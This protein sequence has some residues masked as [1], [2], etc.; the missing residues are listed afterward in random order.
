MVI[1]LKCGN[2]LKTHP[3][4][5]KKSI[6]NREENMPTT[7]C[8]LPDRKHHKLCGQYRSTHM[9][10]LCGREQRSTL[11]SFLRRCCIV[12]LVKGF[13]KAFSQFV[14][15]SSVVR[16]ELNAIYR[17]RN[18]GMQGPL[19]IKITTQNLIRS[20]QRKGSLR[21]SPSSRC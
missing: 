16:D 11:H 2:A 12:T 9:V 19:K 4:A 13:V 6:E 15:Y 3:P 17:I 21:S 7:T 5:A 10:K 14:C 20:K 8:G 18:S 1:I